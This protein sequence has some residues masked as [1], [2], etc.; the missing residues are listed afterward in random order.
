MSWVG[1]RFARDRSRSD[2]SGGAD[3]NPS[4]ETHRRPHAQ[5]SFVRFLGPRSRLR[6]R[7]VVGLRARGRRGVGR[8]LRRPVLPALS[9][10]AVVVPVRGVVLP[11][12]VR[13]MPVRVV[14]AT[15]RIVALAGV[16]RLPRPVM[17]MAVP[18]VR[19]LVLCPPGSHGTPLVV[20]T[21]R[22]IGSSVV[23]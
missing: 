1:R 5:A 14:A 10:R 9:V 12:G 17:A 8:I 13:L 6:L 3:W 2:V 15:V 11:M 4:E 16:A 7:A 20:G 19:G 18:G 22:V 23:R 21:R